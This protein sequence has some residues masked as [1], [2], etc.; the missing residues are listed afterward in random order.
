MGRFVKRVTVVHL[1]TGEHEVHFKRK[2]RKKKKIDGWLRPVERAERRLLKGV[3]TFGD[4]ALDRHKRSRRKKRN[5]FLKDGPRN[6]TRAGSKAMKK[7]IK[8]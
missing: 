4:E 5:A 2:K 3:E 6:F 7:L 8:L 1:S